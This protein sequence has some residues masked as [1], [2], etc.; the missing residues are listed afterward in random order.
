[1]LPYHAGKSFQIYPCSD[2]G[3]ENPIFNNLLNYKL[4]STHLNPTHKTSCYLENPHILV[5][6]TVIYLS[7]KYILWF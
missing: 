6:G 3:A 2:R 4:W 1:M 5:L 7:S